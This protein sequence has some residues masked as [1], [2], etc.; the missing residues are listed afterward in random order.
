MDKNYVPT[1]EISFLLT[2]YDETACEYVTG[3]VKGYDLFGQHLNGDILEAG[4]ASSDDS[5]SP[6]TVSTIEETVQSQTV[7]CIESTYCYGFFAIA[8]DAIKISLVPTS[9]TS[10]SLNITSE[11]ITAGRSVSE[12]MVINKFDLLWS[13]DGTQGQATVCVK[14]SIPP[15]TNLHQYQLVMMDS[16]G[17]YQHLPA[18]SHITHDNTICFSDIDIDTTTFDVNKEVT[19]VATR[20]EVNPRTVIA[21]ADAKVFMIAPHLTS[22]TRRSGRV[23]WNNPGG[24]SFT[25]R[26][27][28][29]ATPLTTNLTCQTCSYAFT[30]TGLG[31]GAVIVE[32]EEG[33]PVKV[34]AT[35]TL[36]HTNKLALSPEVP[37]TSFTLDDT[38][39]TIEVCFDNTGGYITGLPDAENVHM[40][41]TIDSF[42]QYNMPA[43]GVTGEIATTICTTMSTASIDTSKV[44]LHGAYMRCILAVNKDSDPSDQLAFGEASFT[45]PDCKNPSLL[46]D[47]PTVMRLICDTYDPQNPTKVTMDDGTEYT[48]ATSASSTSVQYLLLDNAPASI[49][50]LTVD[51]CVTVEGSPVSQSMLVCASAGVGTDGVVET[52]QH[53]KEIKLDYT[54]SSL[55]VTIADGETGSGTHDLLVLVDNNVLDIGVAKADSIPVCTLTSYDD[56]KVDVNYILVDYDESIS[57]ETYTYWTG[58]VFGYNLDE[59]KL[60]TTILETVWIRGNENEYTVEIDA[61][62]GT[63]N[64][65][66]E[67]HCPDTVVDCYGYFTEVSSWDF[68]ATLK[69]ATATLP[70]L[71]PQ[72]VIVGNLIPTNNNPTSTQ[73][74]IVKVTL[75]MVDKT[76]GMVFHY[77]EAPQDVS[78]AVVT[79]I[80]VDS[81]TSTS[82]QWNEPAHMADSSTASFKKRHTQQIGEHTTFVLKLQNA[83]NE[84][85][86]VT[87]VK[88]DLTA[89]DD[90]GSCDS[91]FLVDGAGKVLRVYCS[92]KPSEDANPNLGDSLM[93]ALSAQYEDNTIYY[94]RESEAFTAGSSFR[95]CIDIEAEVN[96]DSANIGT[97]QGCS[98]IVVITDKPTDSITVSSVTLDYDSQSTQTLTVD[99]TPDGSGDVGTSLRTEIVLYWLDETT[100]EIQLS[101][102]TPAMTE[103][104]TTCMIDMYNKGSR[105]LSITYSATPSDDKTSVVSTTTQLFT[106]YNV[107]G[108]AITDTTAEISWTPSSSSSTYLT[109]IALEKEDDIPI[110]K[111][112]FTSTHV[113]CPD[114]TKFCV[115]RF[116]GLTPDTNYE[117]TLK[118]IET[119]TNTVISEAFVVTSGSMVPI[120]DI[121]QLTRVIPGQAQN[122]EDTALQVQ[123]LSTN[124]IQNVVLVNLVIIHTHDDPTIQYSYEATD[125]APLQADTPTGYNFIVPSANLLMDKSMTLL[126]LMRDA[127]DQNLA[128]SEASVTLKEFPDVKVE[129]VGS[130]TQDDPEVPA[131]LRID[132]C[133]PDISVNGR[134]CTTSS[135]T[136]VEYFLQYEDLTNPVLVCYTNVKDDVG[137]LAGS[138]AQ[139][140]FMQQ[141]TVYAEM[142]GAGAVLTRSKSPVTTTLLITNHAFDTTTGGEVVYYLSGETSSITA[143]EK[144]QT[145]AG[146]DECQVTVSQVPEGDTYSEFNIVVVDL[147]EDRQESLDFLFGDYQVKVEQL[148]VDA[149]EVRWRAT[150]NT[151]YHVN[152]PEG[153][154]GA[155]DDTLVNCGAEE[156]SNCRAYF[157]ALDAAIPLVAEVRKEEDESR[158]NVVGR[159]F[160]LSNTASDPPNRAAVLYLEVD[161]GI[162]NLKVCPRYEQQQQQQG[163]DSFILHP[164]SYVLAVVDLQ[165]NQLTQSEVDPNSE[166]SEHLR[167]KQVGSDTLR[168]LWSNKDSHSHQY[169]FTYSSE[170]SVQPD[171]MILACGGGEDCG[172]FLHFYSPSSSTPIY[173]TITEDD[174]QGLVQHTTLTVPRVEVEE[175]LN[176][177]SYDILWDDRLKVCFEEPSLNEAVRYELGLQKG[178]VYLETTTNPEITVQDDGSICVVSTHEMDVSAYVD[179]W[180]LVTALNDNDGSLLASGED[181]WTDISHVI[182]TVAYTC[183]VLLL[184]TVLSSE[185]R[186]EAAITSQSVLTSWHLL[187]DTTSIDNYLVLLNSGS[188]TVQQLNISNLVQYCDFKLPGSGSYTVCV[189]ANKF[190]ISS[191]EV[192]SDIIT[193]SSKTDLNIPEVGPVAPKSTSETALLVTWDPP[194]DL[195]VTSFLVSWNNTTP[196]ADWSRFRR[197]HPASLARKHFRAQTTDLGF[198]IVPATSTSVEITDLEANVTYDIC[199]VS[200]K[201]D[202]VG[203]M[204]TGQLQHYN[205][206][207]YFIF[208]G[209]YD[210]IPSPTDLKVVGDKLSW[211]DYTTNNDSHTYLVEWTSSQD[212]RG[213]HEDLTVTEWAMSVLDPGEWEVSVRV[214]DG[215]SVSPP[216]ALEITITGVEIN[217]TQDGYKTLH[218]SWVEVGQ[219][220]PVVK[221]YD[222]SI[223]RG[224]SQPVIESGLYYCTGM[225]DDCTAIFEDLNVEYPD[226]GDGVKLLVRVEKIITNNNNKINNNNNYNSNNNI[227]DNYDEQQFVIYPLNKVSGLS[228][229]IKKSNEVVVSWQEVEGAKKYILNLYTNSSHLELRAS[230]EQTLPTMYNLTEKD[231]MGNSLTIQA[232]KDDNHCSET[233]SI[234]ITN[235]PSDNTPAIVLSVLAGVLVL[236]FI[237]FCT[238]YAIKSNQAKKK[239]KDELKKQKQE[240]QRQKEK[241]Q[242]QREEDQRQRELTERQN[243]LVYDQWG[244]RPLGRKGPSPQPP[245]GHSTPSQMSTEG[246]RPSPQAQAYPMVPLN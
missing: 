53:L 49:D 87:A 153:E 26:R 175:E 193:V 158:R 66:A 176:I 140:D 198:T 133:F 79:V 147:Q 165:G 150:V 212:K 72:V 12:E 154:G 7:H 89:L 74:T 21:S 134:E 163:K 90:A 125:S 206:R 166:S 169:N 23:T 145:C 129:S 55:T 37:L 223:R 96:G 112:P 226:S 231:M 117:V 88:F 146:N 135:D 122:N 18:A 4:W 100:S 160:E 246:Q 93:S 97:L 233:T 177:L 168:V 141:M 181:T 105:E 1:D 38:S 27:S 178:S 84:D 86:A 3:E 211:H 51:F 191:E 95:F 2:V 15:T 207:V 173:L 61:S 241:E 139:C 210:P 234:S 113:T 227:K 39:E 47:R 149:I 170:D 194:T 128:Y 208:P 239:L 151:Q 159:E 69:P 161:G 20:R 120:I 83:M 115:V 80:N 192:C 162:T 188:D 35:I 41:C 32:Q 236:A 101:S 196:A 130:N 28:H 33:S 222:V 235:T 214:S 240:E 167:V 144:P 64:P 232:C 123:V 42:G 228:K 24:H 9:G 132:Q 218:V 142:T 200:V 237:T 77:Q 67:V 65:T 107:L 10:L 70:L 245:H 216:T 78:Q 164:P 205:Y 22:L 184:N 189:T 106:D 57:P 172:T 156:E 238:V 103:A 152:L 82:T 180:I 45:F 187:D 225:N 157:I 99:Q 46:T 30:H 213:G 244:S 60:T 109:T 171:T 31:D 224:V 52:S 43:T 229:N 118:P 197:L 56:K 73:V 104:E 94:I 110:H 219:V 174:N 137:V 195:E 108:G 85:L 19:V 76:E 186:V 201:S 62:S 81:A 111:Q 40:T 98:D 68:S 71:S 11:E 183:L 127:N 54:G 59:V 185:R 5:E 230:Y 215:E 119:D 8:P 44:P 116:V 16:Q 126:V 34:T 202:V 63:P 114:A 48:V 124:E 138:V 91:A 217:P 179:L 6:Y 13:P 220:S 155:F 58:S 14:T 243:Q 136:E 148:T 182:E 102:C 209:H 242:R 221:R 25:V 75:E 121:V 17:R 204:N 36:H 190:T 50:G 131:S 199:V 29:E 92:N 203:D 143:P